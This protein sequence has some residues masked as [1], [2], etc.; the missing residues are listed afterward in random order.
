M[1]TITT[2]STES[3]IKEFSDYTLNN[4]IENIRQLLD[5]N[6]EFEIQ[7][8]KKD[9]I[10]VKRDAFIDWYQKKL[11]ARYGEQFTINQSEVREKGDLQ[12]LSLL[13][14]FYSAKKLGVLK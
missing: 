5:I 3:I 10:E 8:E 13:T 14:S 11:E 6:G 7:D 9:S 1:N 2:K 12:T 4:E